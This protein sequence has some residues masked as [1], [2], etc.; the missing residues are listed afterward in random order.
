MDT[1]TSSL[2]T[3][4]VLRQ[5][6]LGCY[7]PSSSLSCLRGKCELLEVILAKVIQAWEAHID[8]D[9]RG[10]MRLRPRRH[11]SRQHIP[12]R[13]PKPAIFP[14]PWNEEETFH[15]NMMPI[16]MGDSTS[17]PPSCQRYSTI[18]QACL[19]TNSGDEIGQVGYLTIHEGIV[20]AGT[21]QRRGGLHIEAGGGGRHFRMAEDFYWGA[22]RFEQH[23]IYG[24]IYMASTVARSCRVYDVT[25]K[26]AHEVTGHLGDIEHLRGVLN[27]SDCCQFYPAKELFWITDRTPHESLPLETTQYRQYFRL[28]TSKVSYWFADH[29]T[30]NPLGIQPAAEIVHG[31]KFDAEVDAAV[32]P[33]QRI[34]F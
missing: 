19:D 17:L 12:G 24:G 1:G 21:S 15:V 30:P 13:L 14:E 6:I 16:I 29:S 31:S 33:L 32:A 5:V 7:D 25:I 3:N 23:R 22:G 27:K 10:M 2:W 18:I 34:P 4:P 28:V 20:E 11:S 26:K 9:T 8:I